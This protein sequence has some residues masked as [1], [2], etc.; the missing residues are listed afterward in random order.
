MAHQK[1]WYGHEPG[2]EHT[3]A[4]IGGDP[5]VVLAGAHIVHRDYAGLGD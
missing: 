2:S 1:M 3:V 4:K 5:L